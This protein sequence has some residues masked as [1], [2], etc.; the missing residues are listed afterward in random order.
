MF[1]KSIAGASDPAVLPELTMLVMVG[2]LLSF[3]LIILEVQLVQLTSSLTLSVIGQVKEVLQIVLSLMIFHDHVTVRAVLGIVVSLLAA[4]Y[5]Q[6]LQLTGVNPSPVS[7]PKSPK[8]KRRNGSSLGRFGSDSTPTFKRYNPFMTRRLLD[9][10]NM[11]KFRLFP[12]VEEDEEE[13]DDD[14]NEHNGDG[15]DDSYDERASFLPQRPVD[16]DE[17][18]T[19]QT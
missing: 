3:L 6:Y 12:I 5:Y 2:G 9:R 4:Q 11:D 15:V 14:N 19:A 1:V 10:I 8:R 18:G 13:T 7:P 17:G 16:P